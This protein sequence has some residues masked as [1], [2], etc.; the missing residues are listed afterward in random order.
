MR[1]L[2]LAFITSTFTT[3]S[4][5]NCGGNFDIFTI[6]LKLEALSM[7]YIENSI[8]IF[9]KNVKKNPKVIKAD[10]NQGIF[11][12]DFISFSQSLISYYRLIHAKKNA[13]K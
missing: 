3:S 10:Q 6:D 7:G 5:A 1:L 4:T 2:I 8:Q 11:Q 12:K 9:F 13:K